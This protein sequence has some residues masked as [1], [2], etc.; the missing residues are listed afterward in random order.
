MASAVVDAVFGSYDLRNA[1]QWRD[2]DLSHRAQ[3]IQWHNDAIRREHEWRAMDLEREK[4]LRKLE[5]ERRMT[6]ARSEQ[7]S[8]ISN[9]SALLGGFAVVAMVEINLSPDINEVLLGFFGCASALVVILMILCMVMC[10]LLLLA[11][12]RYAGHTLELE[13]RHMPLESMDSTSPFYNWWL[14]KCE[15]DWLRAYFFFRSGVSL[16]LFD[17]ALLAFVQF[18]QSLGTATGIAV[19]SLIGFLYWHLH[20]TSKWR[21]LMEFPKEERYIAPPPAQHRSM[22]D[23]NNHDHLELIETPASKM[24]DPKELPSRR[25]PYK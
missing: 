16:F 13:L 2:D 17:L 7:L 21:H 1:K 20:M 24:L 22:R 9:L 8:A 19:L 25:N 15:A 10:T 5:N 3:E 12:T 18:D 4:R 6:D 14:Q 23:M 11:I